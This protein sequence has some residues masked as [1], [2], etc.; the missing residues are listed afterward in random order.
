MDQ[1]EENNQEDFQNE[2]INL[3][4]NEDMRSY[5]YETAKWARFLSIV[6]FLM[7]GLLVMIAF[8]ASAFETALTQT[9]GGEQMAQLGSTMLMIMMLIFALI[10]FYPSLMLF[11]YATSAKTAVLYGD[12]ESL[13][14]AM[15]KMKSFF[16]FWG[17]LTLVMISFYMLSIFA[18]VVATLGA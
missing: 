16:K 2:E 7:T 4:V 3:V 6:G 1:L 14:T 5:L 11:K 12:Q 18:A 15:A 8:S 17:I 13:V 9:P 10:Y